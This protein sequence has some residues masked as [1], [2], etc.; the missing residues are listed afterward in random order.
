LFASDLIVA[1]EHNVKGIFS[2]TESF[3]LDATS[4]ALD[5]NWTWPFVTMPN[6]ELLTNHGRLRSGLEILSLFPIVSRANREKWEDF[7]MQNTAWLYDGLKIQGR[8]PSAEGPTSIPHI[9]EDEHYISSSAST[10]SSASSLSAEDVYVPIFQT[11]PAPDVLSIINKKT[12]MA[13]ITSM[14]HFLHRAYSWYVD[15][16]HEEYLGALN[17]ER[18]TETE[19]H[20]DVMHSTVFSPVRATHDQH[21]DIVAII[22][23]IIPWKR[24]FENLLPTGVNGFVLT[25]DDSCN[26]KISF[27]VDGPEV[28]YLGN[29]DNHDAK[30]DDLKI[31]Y[32]FTNPLHDDMHDANGQQA[33]LRNEDGH[34][35]EVHGGLHND[36]EDDHH[37]DEYYNVSSSAHAEDGSSTKLHHHCQYYVHIYPSYE[38]E[39]RYQTNKAPIYTSIVV[40]I[41]IFTAFIFSFYDYLTTRRQLV[42]QSAAARSQALVSSLFPRTVQQRILDDA[43]KTHLLT[44]KST[45]LYGFRAKSQLKEF[46]EE[47]SDPTMQKPDV[48]RSCPIADLFPVS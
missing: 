17:S 15:D 7:S 25:V 39:Q 11:G 5:R 9:H 36:A 46:L 6:W 20:H 35:D 28:V 14:H 30:Y 24:Y 3:A 18:I 2:V 4:H 44:G 43:Q 31:S 22:V 10:S 16:L 34:Q 42:A 47:D 37:S 8:M 27:R 38:L 23:G 40:L 32:E 48:F 12:F 21:S 33:E 19:G 41:F 45:D 29:L 13:Q 1:L 26:A